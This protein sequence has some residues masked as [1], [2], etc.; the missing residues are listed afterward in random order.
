V[1][2]NISCSRCGEFI[3]NSEK[4]GIGS[5]IISLQDRG[6]LMYPSSKFL[7]LTLAI[8]EFLEKFS[9]AFRQ[10][11]FVSRRLFD[12][13]RPPVER[14]AILKCG[15][16]DSNHSSLIVKIVLGKLVTVYCTNS[17]F[18]ETEKEDWQAKCDNKPM[19]RKVLKL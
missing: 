8:L 2:D 19:S 1:A 17:A 11:D 4:N 6:G 14:S 15:C 12:L 10:I 7:G 3:T 5:Q 13:I 16:G 9:G 18:F